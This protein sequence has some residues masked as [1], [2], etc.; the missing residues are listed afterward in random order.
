MPLKSL[1][2][3]QVNQRR[4]VRDKLMMRYIASYILHLVRQTCYI[5]KIHILTSYMIQEHYINSVD[6]I[7]YIIDLQSVNANSLCFIRIC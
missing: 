3:Y 2:S 7:N 5:Q 4:Y 6:A 1:T